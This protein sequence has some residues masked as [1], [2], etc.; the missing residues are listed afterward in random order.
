MLRKSQSVLEV[1]FESFVLQVKLRGHLPKKTYDVT[2]GSGT[3]QLSVFFSQR[4][5][6]CLSQWRLFQFFA[7]STNFIC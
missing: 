5:S 1:V 2:F 6:N 3:I 7:I 4:F